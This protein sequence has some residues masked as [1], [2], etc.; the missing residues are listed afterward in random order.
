MG[1][2]DEFFN[3]S[4]FEVRN[5]S[6][7]AI[8]VVA[9]VETIIKVEIYDAVGVDYMADV[10]G[11]LKYSDGRNETDI[12]TVVSMSVGPWGMAV[13]SFTVATADWTDQALTLVMS[14]T[15]SS[16]FVYTLDFQIKGT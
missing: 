5:T 9:D 6:G 2:I 1:T 14:V 16:A 10:T 13:V 8:S 11:V 4:K 3:Y 15:S 12:P 7:T